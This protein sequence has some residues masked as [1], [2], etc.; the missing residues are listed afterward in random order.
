MLPLALLGSALFGLGGVFAAIA[1]SN[2]IGGVTA[3]VWAM[4]TARG[5]APA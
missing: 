4:R 5:H 1:L 3:W 2:A